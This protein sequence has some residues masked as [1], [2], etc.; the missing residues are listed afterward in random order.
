MSGKTL[1]DGTIY[2][3]GGG[4]GGGG[5]VCGYYKGSNSNNRTFTFDFEPALFIIHWLSNGYTEARIELI[6]GETRL[7]GQRS[8][9]TAFDR[10]GTVVWNGKSVTLK[11]DSASSSVYFNNGSD[12]YYYIAI[13][14]LEAKT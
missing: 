10:L 6:N 2:T 9:N 1:V 3:I 11:A 8:G 5:A 7:T 4:S 12:T 13:P 14:K